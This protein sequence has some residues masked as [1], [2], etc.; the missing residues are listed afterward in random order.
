MSS[1]VAALTL[2]PAIAPPSGAHPHVWIDSEAT[3]IFVE[4]AL[5]AID[6]DWLLDDMISVILIEDFDWDRTG[7]FSDEQVAALADESFAG[8]AEFNYFVNLRIDGQE[9]GTPDIDRFQARIIDDRV[10]YS[11]RVLLPAPVDP[12]AVPVMVGFYDETFFVDVT[13]TEETLHFA[14]TNVPACTPRI[15]ADTD[16]PIYFGFVDPPTVDLGCR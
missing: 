5:Q 7:S 12:T 14:G 4:G 16:N 1:I 9:Q 11:F 3:F 10:G 8:L 13:A 15:F 6:I 2:N